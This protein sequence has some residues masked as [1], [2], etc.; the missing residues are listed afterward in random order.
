MSIGWDGKKYK[1]DA[2]WDEADSRVE[3]RMPEWGRNEK[4]KLVPLPV[5]KQKAG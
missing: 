5:K 1:I 4:G 3:F 2:Y